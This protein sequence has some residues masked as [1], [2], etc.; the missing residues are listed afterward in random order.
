[1]DQSEQETVPESSDSTVAVDEQPETEPEAAPESATGAAPTNGRPDPTRGFLA[2]LA[3]AMRGAAERE[4]E[5]ISA[6]VDSSAEAHVEKVRARAATEAAE[7]RRLAD[8]DIDGIH[9]W[10]KEETIRIQQ[11][12]ER[13][14][15][16]RREELQSY[17]IRH[18]AIIDGEVGQIE[19]AVREYRAVLDRFF[20]QLASE[21]DPSGLARV[22][23]AMPAPPDLAKVGSAA[24]AQAVAELAEEQHAADAGVADAVASAE[25]NAFDPERPGPELVPVMGESNGTVN[26]TAVVASVVASGDKPKADAASTGTGESTEADADST[27]EH[28][29]VA[30]RLL[31]SIASTLSAPAEHPTDAPETSETPEPAAAD[32]SATKTDDAKS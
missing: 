25:V 21:S 15:G 16:T 4:R 32:D 23:D 27:T 19:G 10:S 14:I 24:R 30:V 29:N 9:S 28:P 6:D 2:E 31:R 5:R 11:E 17:L 13:R 3:H 1:M 20:A 26:A 12:T 22:A 8:Q 18:A 7:L